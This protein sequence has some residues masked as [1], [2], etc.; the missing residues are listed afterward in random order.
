VV[1]ETYRPQD[2]SLVRNGR[3]SNSKLIFAFFPPIT[4]IFFSWSPEE[5][6]NFD[7]LAQPLVLNDFP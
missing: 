6:K 3:F 1:L 5:R 2:A 7:D 4:A